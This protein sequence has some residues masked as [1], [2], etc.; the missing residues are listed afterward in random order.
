[1]AP[2]RRDYQRHHVGELICTKFGSKTRSI[3]APGVGYSAT[4]G[5]GFEFSECRPT[6]ADFSALLTFERNTCGPL[7]EILWTPSVVLPGWEQGRLEAS[8]SR[9]VLLK[10]N[11]FNV[12][13]FRL[14]TPLE[15]SRE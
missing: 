14:G 8:V 7:R 4:A 11:G 6:S 15:S 1:V 10:E 5:Q 13:I 9:E 3:E 12:A 2:T